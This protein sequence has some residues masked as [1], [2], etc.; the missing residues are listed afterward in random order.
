MDNDDYIKREREAD[1]ERRRKL[2]EEQEAEK[3]GY[4]VIK[5]KVV[6]V[7]NRFEKDAEPYRKVGG[8]IK[9]PFEEARDYVATKRVERDIVNYKRHEEEEAHRLSIQEAAEMKVYGR[10]L[11]PVERAKVLE[12]KQKSIEERNAKWEARKQKFRQFNENLQQLNEGTGKFEGVTTGLNWEV[13]TPLN[14]DGLDSLYGGAGSNVNTEKWFVQR[15]A[16]QKQAKQ[17]QQPDPLMTMFSLGGGVPKN[18][19]DPLVELYNFGKGSTLGGSRKK[20]G[21]KGSHPLDFV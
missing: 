13:G 9:K 2:L 18:G 12:Q 20:K 6:S 14:Y 7:K 21:K 15:Q 3:K 5:R 8:Q 4:S 17:S 16:P 1:D 11:T 10:V 19:K